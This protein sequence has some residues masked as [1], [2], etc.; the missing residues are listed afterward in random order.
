VTTQNEKQWLVKANGGILQKKFCL[1]WSHLIFCKQS[2][3]SDFMYEK[4]WAE[5]ILN[6]VPTPMMLLCQTK[7]NNP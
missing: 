5:L 2:L 1:K 6:K 3:A 7:A 4:Y